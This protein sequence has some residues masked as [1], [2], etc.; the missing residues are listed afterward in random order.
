MPVIET[1]GALSSQGLGEFS[2]KPGPV[3][4]EDVFSSYL[5]AGTG[6]TQTI[7]NNINLSGK[8]GMVWIKS[9]S[10]ATD[11]A[12]YDTVR[13]ATFDLVSNSTAAQTTQS[14]GLTAFNTSGFDIGTLAKLN[15]SAARYASWTFRRQNK[16]FDVRTVAHTNGTADVLDFSNLGTIGMVIYKDTGASQDWFVWHRTLTGSDKLVLNSDAAVTTSTAFS[17]SGTTITVASA[18]TTGTKLIYAFAHDAGGFGLSGT[19]NVISCGSYTGNGST[20]GPVVTLNYEPQ[21]ILIKRTDTT[22]AWNMLDYMRGLYFIGN[23]AILFPNATTIET[24]ENRITPTATGFQLITTNAAFNANNGN[25]IYAAI[26]RGQMKVPTSGTNMFN[27]IVVNQTETQQTSTNTFPPDVVFITSLN[28]TSRANYVNE[29]AD[30]LRSLGTPNDTFSVA[31]D[32]VIL[33]THTTAVEDTANTYIQLKTNGID[34]TRGGSWNSASYGNFLYYFFRRAA[35]FLDVVCY[36]G[37]GANATQTHNLTVVPELI[38]VK[39]R[40]A[41]TGAWSVYSAAL[42]NTEYLVLNTTAAKATGATYWNSTTPTATTFSLGTAADV[43]ASTGTYVA[44]LFASAAGVSKVGSYSGTGALQTINCGFTS[45]A[46]FVFIKRTDSTGDWFVYDST[47]GIS[48]SN[49][50]YFL[51]NSSAVQVTNTNYVDTTSTG[52]QVT[53]AAP[54]GLNANGGS[55]IFLA[56]A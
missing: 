6:A 33:V 5:Y 38:I 56:I 41:S 48:S 45:G 55:Y 42:L 10:A 43:N 3:Y 4:I 40:A 52:F 16:F 37:T 51:F 34:I 14:T 46:R 30:R 24:L 21:W 50:P 13:G 26:R 9:R 20:A 8:G 1:K 27:A 36:T 31:T 44:Y 32:G 18:E 49:D 12:L 23:D 22:G 17:V 2:K 19:D 11:H 28:G 53:A 29:I 15:T 47:R 39:R 54:A 25:Y 7:T 35:G